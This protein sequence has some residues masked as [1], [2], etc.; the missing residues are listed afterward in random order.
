MSKLL[1][2]FDDD[3]SLIFVEKSSKR[4][5]FLF[6]SANFP[7]STDEKMPA[8]TIK[9]RKNNRIDAITV[10]MIDAISEV[11]KVFIMFL[12]NEI[13]LMFYFYS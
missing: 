6:I 5:V 3:L 2:G 9:K 10:P 13:T 11:K 8:I 1:K 12:L 4:T 7:F